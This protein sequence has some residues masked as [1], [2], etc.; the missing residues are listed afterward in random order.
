LI[1][2]VVGRGLRQRS[3]P[4]NKRAALTANGTVVNGD[5]EVD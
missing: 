5:D 4:A 2:G 1:V 3:M